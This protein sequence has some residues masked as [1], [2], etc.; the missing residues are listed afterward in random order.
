ML[1][2]F[3]SFKSKLQWIPKHINPI[4]TGYEIIKITAERMGYEMDLP[5][6]TF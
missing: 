6:I 3:Q 4:N 1:V 5:W 2:I